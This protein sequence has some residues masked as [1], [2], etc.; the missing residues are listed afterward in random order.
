[1]Q[2]HTKEFSD[3]SYS[4]HLQEYS[5][6]C[7]LASKKFHS[8]KRFPST[9]SVTF[10]QAKLGER[11]QTLWFALTL[12]PRKWLTEKKNP[13]SLQSLQNA[14]SDTTNLAVKPNKWNILNGRPIT[15]NKS[16]SS[17]RFNH[18]L[19]SMSTTIRNGQHMR[20]TQQG[21]IKD[22]S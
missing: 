13:K 18:F 2:A 20:Y 5:N 11:V 10:L 14:Q 21:P 12:P 15:Y 6:V 7:L 17:F 4:C 8:P 22:F 1:M 3:I 16:S 9:F 19:D